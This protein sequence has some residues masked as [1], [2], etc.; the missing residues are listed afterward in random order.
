MVRRTRPRPHQLFTAASDDREGWREQALPGREHALFGV[1]LGHVPQVR[2]A[3][4]GPQGRVVQQRGEGAGQGRIV[5]RDHEG[6]LRRGQHVG[7]VAHAGGGNGAAGG[8]R[9]QQRDGHLLRVGGEH[10]QVHG[11]QERDRVCDVPGEDGP[12]RDAEFGCQPLERRALRAV[13]HDEQAAGQWAV[14]AC[15]LGEGAHEAA[16]VL[17][18]P[19]CRDGAHHRPFT[20]ERHGRPGLEAPQVDPVRH[21][22]HPAGREPPRVERDPLQ[23]AGRHHHVPPGQRDPARPDPARQLRRAFVRAEP[24][25]HVQVRR[26]LPAVRERPF[27]G[28]PVAR[29]EHGRAEP[30]QR[31]AEKPERAHEVPLRHVQREGGDIQARVQ[32]LAARGVAVHG[33]DD[34]AQARAE[35]VRQRTEPDLSATHGE[36]RE[37]MEHEGGGRHGA[38]VAKGR[39]SGKRGGSPDGP[40]PLLIVSAGCAHQGA[41]A[42]GASSCLDDRGMG[43]LKAEPSPELVKQDS[44]DMQGKPAP[45]MKRVLQDSSMYLL[46]NLMTRLVGFLAIPFYSRFL[47][48][49]QYGLIELVELST[50]T[51]AIALGLQ[52]IGTALTRLYHDEVSEAGQRAV[53]S[54]CVLTSL[55]LSL[56][57]TIVACAAAES[58]SG[59]MF[60]TTEYTRLLQAAFVAM[61]FAN[62]VE[63]SLVWERMQSNARLYLI[64]TVVST[65]ALLSLNILFIGVL[66]FGV[67]G[68]VSSKLIV[69]AISCVYLM[70]RVGRTVGWAYR[71][72]HVP[73]LA[74]F[75]AP[76]VLSG[77]SYFAIHFSDRFFLS[78]PELLADLGRYSLAYRFAFLISMLVGDSFAKSWGATLYQYTDEAGWQARFAR[79]ASYFAFVLFGAG[80]GVVLF[81]P[82]LLRLMVPPDFLPPPLILPML[83]AA[84]VARE[85]GDFFRSLMLI[86]KRSGLV[87]Q[88]ALGSALFNLG[89]NALLIPTFGIIGAAGATFITW[90]AYMLVCWWLSQREHRLPVSAWAFVRIALLAIAVCGVASAM[91]LHG[92]LPQ[93]VLDGLWTLLFLGLAASLFLTDEERQGALGVAGS[94]ALWA[95]TRQRM[96]PGPEEAAAEAHP[97]VVILAYYFPPQNEIGAA[98]P[99]RFA[100][101]LRRMGAS[102]TVVTSAE[103]AAGPD[104]MVVLHA[105]TPRAIAAGGAVVANDA[106][107]R[108]RVRGLHVA[109]RALMPYDDRL[110]W[111]PGAY[112]A[113]Q[114]ALRPG[115]VVLS[116]HPPLVT[117]LV[118]LALKQKHGHPWI[119]DF[120]DPLYGNPSRTSQRAS[121]LDPVLER[122]VVENADVVIANTEMAGRQLRAR[123]P[124]QAHKIEV[125]WNGYDP[126]DGIEP[127]AAPV[128][129]RFALTHVGTMYANRTLLPIVLSV[130]RLID[131]GRLQP[132]AFVLRQVGR[133]DP[134]CLDLEAPVMQ[135]LLALGCLEVVNRNVP[136]AEAHA[137]MREANGL[138]LLDMTET[139]RGVQVPGKTYEYIRTGRPVLALT[140]PGSSTQEVLARSGI[141]HACVD[142]HAPVEMFD[143]AVLAFLQAPARVSRPSEAF[144]QTFSATAQTAHLMRL[145]ERVRPA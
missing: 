115:S 89:A 91:R 114:N 24:V 106:V 54:T 93:L 60:H 140:V 144:M 63:I 13:T 57:V 61:F 23:G 143:A 2:L 32:A 82:D 69:T 25:F 131:Q 37:G 101:G 121:M 16:H 107:L 39:G 105:P 84:Y 10:E 104:G 99:G 77:L 58:L 44:A 67:W 65:C 113:A 124:V 129:T 48:P 66:N 53:A 4:F 68:F 133:A 85:I 42:R 81:G 132:D 9:L 34:V 138:L 7:H 75:G 29:H 88:V 43:S 108:M 8:H 26:D 27:D 96:G 79:V 22:V 56:V 109:E 50:Q 97:S 64:Y 73:E 126:A 139:N 51:I 40:R 118:A 119:A 86:N 90:F 36:T 38:C 1:G 45:R 80:V 78:A 122:V 100:R 6:V 49:A 137:A 127:S 5:D 52:A 125:I 15:R 18:G 94:V 76:L 120:R 17:F 70:A 62:I 123:Y 87:G 47:T 71:W 110:G 95:L 41:V 102:V 135:A 74:R 28:A 35:M 11:V 14:G 3:E 33:D 112:D 21:Q 30:T 128:T 142:L 130:A 92:L 116:T 20:G 83:I 145:I 134:H 136:L 46:A 31:C 12:I 111:F 72:S 59:V 103:G 117:H 19:Q 55:G 141:D 98:R